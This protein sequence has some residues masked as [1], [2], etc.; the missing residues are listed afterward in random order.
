MPPLLHGNTLQMKKN[1]GRVML[2]TGSAGAVGVEIC[3]QLA[4]SGATV[5]AADL[6]DDLGRERAAGLTREGLSVE[7]LRLDVSDEASWASLA[8]H[9]AKRHRRLDATVN[10]AGTVVVKPLEDTSLAEW[11]RVMAVN[12]DS[13]FLGSK[14]VLPLMRTS[15]ATTPQGGSI[16][17]MSSISGIIGTPAMP[18]YGASKG[19]VRQLSKSMALDFAR[20]GYRIRVN[21]VHPGL[22]DTEMAQ[23]LFEGR[24]EAGVSQTV[25]E[26]RKSWVDAYPIGRIGTGADVAAAVLYLVSDDSGF[27]TGSE[28]VVDGGA[29]AQ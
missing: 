24:V 27:T 18:A 28:L 8:G 2:V 26:A 14:A 16:V 10:C 29:T 12:L 1:D 7:F 15:A 20:R 9:I 6:N 21:S 4:W 25:E 23:R 22:I 13:I 17:N 11:R 5:V 3:R 19:A